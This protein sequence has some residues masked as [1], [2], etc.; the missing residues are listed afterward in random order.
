MLSHI[1]DRKKQGT[2]FRVHQARCDRAYSLVLH[3]YPT[4]LSTL[5]AGTHPIRD[6]DKSAAIFKGLGECV[7]F[8]GEGGDD[9]G[10][11]D[12]DDGPPAKKR[13]GRPAAGGSKRAG[14]GSGKKAAGA[15]KGKGKAKR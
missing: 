12:E 5:L 2:A 11:S 3:T 1:R 14:K 7:P 4:A 10:G 8:E 6:D 15:K 13:R 9:G